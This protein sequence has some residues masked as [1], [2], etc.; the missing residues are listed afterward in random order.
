[1]KLDIIKILF[2]DILLCPVFVILHLNVDSKDTIAFGDAKIDIP[3]FEICG[4][5]VAM[6][7]AGK[8]TKE[9][10]DYITTDVNDDGMYN[11]FKHLGLI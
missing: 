7:N 9:A 5:G 3:M 6:G 11:A 4:Y 10:A 1:M 2:L 8:E